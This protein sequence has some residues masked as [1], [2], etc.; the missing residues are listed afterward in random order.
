MSIQKYFV[1]EISEIENEILKNRVKSLERRYNFRSLC[2]DNG[3][4]KISFKGYLLKTSIKNIIRHCAGFPK[5]KIK[6]INIELG[7][8]YSYKN[9]ISFCG[10]GGLTCTTIFIPI[11]SI[12]WQDI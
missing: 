12:L 5:T 2:E 8:N 1:T 9:D 11:N 10:Y 3:D 4:I 7:K 6:D